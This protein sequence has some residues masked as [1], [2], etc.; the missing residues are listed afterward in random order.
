MAN[1]RF[2]GYHQAPMPLA[3]VRA[4]RPVLGTGNMPE[5]LRRMAQTK[6]IYL[7]ADSSDKPRVQ[8]D[9]IESQ[10]HRLWRIEVPVGERL[11]GARPGLTLERHPSE[12]FLKEVEERVS[13]GSHRP[14]W[15]DALP[16]PRLK[17]EAEA[18]MLRRFDGRSTQPL[19]VYDGARH[20]FK[21]AR[22]A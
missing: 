16:L 6:V 8:V 21:R 17:L 1:H 9:A 18:P 3:A 5:D 7:E 10:R 11:K 13:F 22:G 4:R 12:R 2:V 19:W 15:I 14:E 20:A